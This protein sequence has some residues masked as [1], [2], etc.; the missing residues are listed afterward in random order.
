MTLILSY[1]FVALSQG[2]SIYTS[3]LVSSNKMIKS[4][5]LLHKANNRH[6]LCLRQFAVWKKA[7]GVE[8]KI[9]IICRTLPRTLLLANLWSQQSFII[10]IIIIIHEFHRDASL[11]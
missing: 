11:E 2:M 10:I 9:M 6:G 1:Y 8:A 4:S 3:A 5:E 7:K